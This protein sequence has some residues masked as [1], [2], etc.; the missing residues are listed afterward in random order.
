MLWAR[1]AR[2]RRRARLTNGYASRRC[3]APS[4][5]AGHQFNTATEEV[6]ALTEELAHWRKNI[7]APLLLNIYLDLDAVGENATG[8]GGLLLERWKLLFDQRSAPPPAR[9]PLTLPCSSPALPS[10]VEVPT[11]YKKTV[12]LIRSL[13]TYLRL[14]PARRLVR[15][16][17]HHKLPRALRY[18]LSRQ[19]FNPPF[20]AGV[21]CSECRFAALDTP[22]G[23]FSVHVVFRQDCNFKVCALFPLFFP[24]LAASSS[25]LIPAQLHDDT[26][27]TSKFIIQDYMPDAKPPRSS[28]PTPIPGSQ[29]ISAPSTP[30]SPP[31]SY[32]TGPIVGTSPMGHPYLGSKRAPPVLFARTR[33]TLS[34]QPCTAPP[35][36]SSPPPPS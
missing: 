1:G 10:S 22:Y 6:E 9:P 16:A 13:F 30:L 26:L 29:P 28:P 35:R 17:Q 25:K 5:T 18:A 20:P 23:R 3:C 15:E 34:R 7:F 2:C 21:S 8:R 27:I 24:A 33:L 36:P 11:L 19:E 14:M 31:N 12:V 32:Q 4:L